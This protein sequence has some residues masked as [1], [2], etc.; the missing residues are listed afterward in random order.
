MEEQKWKAEKVLGL[1][2][3]IY[4]PKKYCLRQTTMLRRELQILD[5]QEIEVKVLHALIHGPVDWP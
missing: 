2:A 3:T 5:A 4:Y 1:C